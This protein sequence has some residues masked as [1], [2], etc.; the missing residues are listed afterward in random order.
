MSQFW[1]DNYENHKLEFWDCPPSN[2]FS[3]DARK[4][5]ERLGFKSVRSML[6]TG[7]SQYSFE[8]RT[9]IFRQIIKDPYHVPNDALVELGNLPAWSSQRRLWCISCRDK[10]T[11]E[12]VRMAEIALATELR[13][14]Y[15]EERSEDD[16]YHE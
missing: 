14:P 6:T 4:W 7:D 3:S 11:W 12:L 5:V 16:E 9:W 15:N 8:R 2:R 13:D 10:A 1:F